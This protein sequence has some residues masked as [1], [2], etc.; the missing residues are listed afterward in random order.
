MLRPI[1]DQKSKQNGRVCL[2]LR[3]ALLWWR[4]ILSMDIAELKQW[5]QVTTRPVHMFCDAAGRKPH[6]GVVL[7]ID[8]ECLWTHMPPPQQVMSRFRARDDNQIMGLE[9]LAISLGLSTFER[10]LRGRK[11][12]IHSDNSGSEVTNLDT[13]WRDCRHDNLVSGFSPQGICALV[14][15]CTIGARAMASRSTKRY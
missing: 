3:R 8:G 4:D 9:L 14:G 7:F 5:K 13:L 6:L 11:V 15:P 1:F 12:F 10:R 2:E